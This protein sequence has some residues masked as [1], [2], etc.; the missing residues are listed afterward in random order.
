MSF[1]CASEWRD[2]TTDGNHEANPAAWLRETRQEGGP[3]R[4]RLSLSMHPFFVVAYSG[5]FN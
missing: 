5:A 1:H 2:A 4:L 3:L